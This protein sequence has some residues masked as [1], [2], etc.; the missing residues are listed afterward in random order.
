MIRP[1]DQFGPWADGLDAAEQRARLRAMRALARVHCGPRGAEFCHW[2]AR[3]ELRHPSASAASS[4]SMRRGRGWRAAEAVPNPTAHPIAATM[5]QSR[6]MLSAMV[7]QAT[8]AKAFG[9]AWR[10]SMAKASSAPRAA[11]RILAAACAC[12]SNSDAN[13]ADADSARAIATLLSGSVA[14]NHQR[15]A[16]ACS[17]AADTILPPPSC[18]VLNMAAHEF[19]ICSTGAEKT[20]S[21][22]KNNIWPRYDVMSDIISGDSSFDSNLR[23]SYSQS[24]IY[25]WLPASRRRRLQG[26]AEG[27]RAL[28]QPPQESQS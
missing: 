10:S 27:L 17:A 2:L 3:A 5:T 19:M 1:R 6:K 21:L 26:S 20:N 25:V 12:W 24:I 8:S 14:V 28:A 16:A 4:H 15:L 7:V 23:T 11:D 9:G 22:S 13:T 18:A